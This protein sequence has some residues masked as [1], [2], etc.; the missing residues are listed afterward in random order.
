MNTR[1]R[2]LAVLVPLLMAAAMMEGCLSSSSSD[3]ADPIDPVDPVGPVQVSFGDEG[4]DAL[5]WGPDLEVTAFFPGHANWQWLTD[6]NGYSHDARAHEVGNSHFGESGVN[7]GLS[8]GSVGCHSAAEAGRTPA[9]LGERLVDLKKGDYEKPGHKIATVNAAYDSEFFYLRVE[10]E[11]NTIS[12]SLTHQMFRYEAG[13]GFVGN[14]GQPRDFEADRIND[15]DLVGNQFYNYEDRIAVMHNPT[16]QGGD[17]GH[18]AGV[19]FNNQGCFIACHSS[20]R[21]QPEQVLKDGDNF[22]GLPFAA[23]SDIRHYLLATRDLDGANAVSGFWNEMADGY[24]RTAY[25]GDG[26]FLDLWQGRVARSMPM[27]HASN[28][29]VI[30]YRLSGVDGT[31]NWFDNRF[32]DNPGE[33]GA[34][35]WPRWIYDPRVTGYW[36][37]HEDEIHDMHEAGEGPLRTVEYENVMSGEV[38]PRNGVE[39][40][41]LFDKIG[42]EWVLIADV[43]VKDGDTVPAGT[44]A[45]EIFQEGDLIPRRALR[46]ASGARAGVETY[47][48][49]DEGTTTV[50]FKRHLEA[51]HDSDKTIDLNTGHTMA[52][53][54]FDDNVSNRSHYVSLPFTVQF[55]GGDLTPGDN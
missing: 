14:V 16:A 24:D 49:W 9:D 21:N 17:V 29:Y 8:C 20:M 39:F 33:S 40:E 4:L 48:K 5:N 22:D 2:K 1:K 46:A 52:I 51:R 32:S 38:F 30:D 3:R 7:A 26:T 53:A 54:L 13:A 36:A 25:R 42:G 23:E 55:S 18:A 31:N 19:N 35:G 43:Q 44:P 6:V 50:V 28:D 10:Y 15:D 41:E 12:P 27:G 34:D 11:S 47:W 37:I 45:G